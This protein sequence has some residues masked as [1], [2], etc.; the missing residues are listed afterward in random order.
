MH[1]LPVCNPQLGPSWFRPASS[2]DGRHVPVSVAPL[3][4]GLRSAGPH[5]LDDKAMVI[6]PTI[7]PPTN[8]TE[9]EV[10]Q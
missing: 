7:E 1:R 6:M 4:V 9:K 8:N 2:G 5:H 3:S 10:R